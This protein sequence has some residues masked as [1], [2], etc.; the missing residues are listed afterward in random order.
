MSMHL[1]Y[2]IH[3][4]VTLL[5]NTQIIHHPYLVPYDYPIDKVNAEI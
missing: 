2:C 4:Q 1:S 3:A 5:A